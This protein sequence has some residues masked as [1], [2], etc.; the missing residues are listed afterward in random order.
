MLVT[1]MVGG[2]TGKLANASTE[3]GSCGQALRVSLPLLLESCCQD[4]LKLPPLL[5]CFHNDKM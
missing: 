2:G 1:S 3:V 4:S 5:K